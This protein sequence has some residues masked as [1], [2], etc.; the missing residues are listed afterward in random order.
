MKKIFFLC[1]ISV[2]LFAAEQFLVPKKSNVEYELTGRTAMFKVTGTAEG[3]K[4]SLRIAENKLNG[5]IVF[6]LNSLKS[7]LA[8]RDEIMKKTYLETDRFSEAKLVFKSF[9]MPLGWSL[10]NPKIT[11]YSFKATL[12]L[13]GVEKDITGNFSIEDKLAK[14]NAK[15]DVKLSEFKIKSPEYLGVKIGDIVKINVSLEELTY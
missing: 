4:S 7:D 10:K 13:H 2:R 3:L 15:F 5:E 11:L 9:Q 8:E 14:V 6:D 12:V 1:F